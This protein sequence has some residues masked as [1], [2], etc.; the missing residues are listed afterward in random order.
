MIESADSTVRHVV[1]VGLMGSGKT[2]VGQALADRINRR[3]LDNDRELERR[4]D[5]TAKELGAALSTEVLH[6]HEFEILRD[7]LTTAEPSIIGAA[8]SV[9]DRPEI[10]ALLA[11]HHVVWLDCPIDWLAKR[12]VGGAH[13]PLTPTSAATVLADQLERRRPALER[14]SDLRLQLD[15]GGPNG[16]AAAIADWLDGGADA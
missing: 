16:R 10:D 12:A 6:Q 14:V 7:Q 5:R 11:P 13:R 1:L 2:S 4:T 3:L 9:L 15:G 8:A